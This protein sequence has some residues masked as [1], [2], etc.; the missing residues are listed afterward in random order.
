[1]GVAHSTR[2]SRS[3]SWALYR[4]EGHRSVLLKGHRFALRVAKGN[5]FCT[6]CSKIAPKYSR[7]ANNLEIIIVLSR[8]TWN[9]YCVRNAIE[10]LFLFDQFCFFDVLQSRTAPSVLMGAKNSGRDH[11]LMKISRN[12]MFSYKLAEADFLFFGIVHCHGQ[13]QKPKNCRKL[14][15][16]PPPSCGCQRDLK[17]VTPV[18]C[19]CA[20][21]CV[22]VC[23]Y[24]CVCVTVC[25]C[26]RER[27]RVCTL[28][29]TFMRA[30][31]CVV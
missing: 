27:V 23:V 15:L 21:V 25:V 30:R 22:C 8:S 7:G 29:A 12:C 13:F 24:M 14:P 16:T 20:C 28:R 4:S 19:V 5:R 1:M 3:C 31:T 11:V 2:G 26:E 6:A 17:P 9:V 18:P 10:Q